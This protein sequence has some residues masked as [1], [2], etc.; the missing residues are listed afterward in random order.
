MAETQEATDGYNGEFHLGNPTT[1]YEL[2]QVKSFDIPDPGDRTQEDITHLKS[3]GRRKEYLS[4]WYEDSDFTVTLNGRPMSTTDTLLYDA[5]AAGNVRP[6]KAV[7]PEDGV[8]TTQITGTCK[9]ISYSRGT[10]EDGIMEATATLRVVTIDAIA[11][12]ATPT[13]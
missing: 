5:R 12:Y 1:L 6:F 8:P 13:P 9:V 4:T 10:V 2:I 7:L 3:A 11:A